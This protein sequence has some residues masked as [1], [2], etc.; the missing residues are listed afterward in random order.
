[1]EGCFS[2]A[3]LHIL[4]GGKRPKQWDHGELVKALCLRALSPKAFTYVREQLKFPL[5]GLSTLGK[6]FGKLIKCVPGL[7]HEVL[8]LMEHQG[9]IMDDFEKVCVLSFDEMKIDSRLSYDASCDTLYGPCNQMMVAMVR[10]L[11]SYW[12]QPIFYAFDAK[13]KEDLWVSIV[14]AVHVAGFHVVANVCDMGGQNMSLWRQLHITPEKSYCWHPCDPTRPIFF[15]ADAP[16]LMKLIRNHLI[17]RGFQLGEISIN[18]QPLQELIF[19]NKGD[20]RLCH[21]VSEGHLNLSN[22]EKQRVRPA[23]QLLSHTVAQGLRHSVPQSDALANFIDTVNDFF[24]VFNSRCTME[25]P[26]EKSGYGCKLNN[27]D[28]ALERMLTLCQSMRIPGARHLL[29]FQKG[30][31]VSIASL[32]GL[33]HFVRDRYQAKYILTSRLNQDCL[34]NLFGQIRALGRTYVNPSPVSARHRFRSLLLT[35]GKNVVRIEGASVAEVNDGTFFDS[36]SRSYEAASTSAS[37]QPGNL[38]DIS[39]NVPEESPSFPDEFHQGKNESEL[40]EFIESGDLD[41]VPADCCSREDATDNAS[42]ESNEA[43]EK[44]A[45]FIAFKLKSTCPELSYGSEAV[46]R[47]WLDRID[48]GGLIKPSTSWLNSVI[49]LERDFQ[50]WHGE[51]FRNGGLLISDLVS[52]LKSKYPH[53]PHEALMLFVRTRT[54]FRIKRLNAEH[55]ARIGRRKCAKLKILQS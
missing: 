42:H 20:V 28:A 48:R 29:P 35:C 15:F 27:Q 31:L 11:F 13:M 46:S 6:W 23:I 1:M 55:E 38:L 2:S 36:S 21:K 45:G 41:Q 5:P 37:G 25:D 39:Y 26:P 4:K 52:H 17:D 50:V 3:Q 51:R 33:F 32:R 19:L 44:V 8:N 12:K 16:H 30:I 9:R 40:S 54:F 7:Q 43:L 47:N 18:K 53:I 24:D 10:G 14:E 34:E 49:Q 22:I